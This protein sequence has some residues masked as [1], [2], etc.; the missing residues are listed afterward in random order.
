[1]NTGFVKRNEKSGPTWL[2]SKKSRARGARAR[3]V[4]WGDF[5]N[6][7]SI[8]QDGWAKIKWGSKRYFLPVEDIATERPLEVMF[9]DVG[10]GDG[11]VVVSPEARTD[12]GAADHERE[13]IM[14]IDAGISDNM[15]GF[16]RWRFGK[17]KRAF[18][19]HAAIITHPDADHYRGFQKIF[20]HKNIEFDRIYHNG[21]M[22]RTGNDLLG[23]T[24]ASGRY[25]TGIVAS[26]TAVR[27]LYGDPAVRG[28]KWYPRLLHTAMTSGRVGQ[29]EMLS[30]KHGESEAGRQWIPGFAPSS[31]RDVAIEVIGPVVER[32]AAGNDR[33]RWFGD[34]I[35]SSA[36]NTGKT[37]NGHS[38]LLRLTLRSFK[39]FFGGDLNAPAEDFLLRHYG[40]I[41][42]A[43][44][45]ADAVPQASTRL[46][47]DVMKSCHH[48]SNDVTDELLK[49][50]NPF[51]FVISSGDE[52]SHA[53]PRP[54]LLGRLGK[55]G[56]GDAP[57]LLCTELL[58]STREEGRAADFKKLALL[59]KKIEAPTTSDADRKKLR[60]ERA[61]L[62]KFIQ[63]RNVGVYGAITVRTDGHHMEISF[64]LES[65][66]GKQSWQRYGFRQ[67]AHDEWVPTGGLTSH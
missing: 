5:L 16:L 53:H 26:D 1:M 38:V 3:D 24:D 59:N 12:A 44:A 41:G 19:F 30:T 45:L 29:I 14:V 21:L 20:S 22:E 51:A 66:R 39:L 55:F 15:F 6:I 56:R 54:D 36:K 23:P 42:D 9:L 48:G 31:G 60:Q 2:Y 37:K 40:G 43:Q 33:L 64:K 32:D 61:R 52:E 62:T 10:Q 4:R 25:L 8:D 58:R 11:C 49:A 18:R 13:R 7:E 65:P 46:S 35:G 34:G 28:R 47:A 50:V 57:L 67:G 63:Q 17:L 27:T